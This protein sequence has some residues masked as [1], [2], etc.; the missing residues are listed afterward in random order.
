MSLEAQYEQQRQQGTNDKTTV[1]DE[2]DE[3]VQTS[4]EGGGE[5]L[6]T[7]LNTVAAGW[8]WLDFWVCTLHSLVVVAGVDVDALGVAHHQAVTVAVANLGI[9]AGDVLG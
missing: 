7:G 3:V 1:W 6:R 5:R 2:R 4:A 8:I 9:D